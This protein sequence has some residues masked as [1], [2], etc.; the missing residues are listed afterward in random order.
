MPFIGYTSLLDN[1]TNFDSWYNGLQTSITKRF[2]HGL[3]FLGS[4]T[5]SKTLDDL[6]DTTIGFDSGRCGR[7]PGD[8]NLSR[9]LEWGP[10]EFDRAHRFVLSYIRAMPQPK[11]LTGFVGKKL[12]GMQS[13]GVVTEQNGTPVP[14]QDQRAGSIIA[15]RV[16]GYRYGQVCPG[17]TDGQL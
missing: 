14:I 4:Y 16:S 8:G 7:F 5:W 11:E 17:F 13:S 2:N 6:S 12:S 10:T 15:F 3:Q 9:S 1:E